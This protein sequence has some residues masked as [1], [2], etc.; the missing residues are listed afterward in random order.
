[1]SSRQVVKKIFANFENSNDGVIRQGITK[2]DHELL[3]PFVSLAEFS[4]SPPGGF[5]DHPHRGE[6]I[7]SFLLYTYT[8]PTLFYNG[9]LIHQDFN[10]NKGT[11]HEGDVLWTTAGR[12]IIHSE[13]PKEHTNIGLQL[14]VNL[15]SSDKMID[16]AN[17]EISSSEMPVAYEEGVEV[18]VI[19]GVSMGVQSPFYT[20]TPIMFL[21]II[22]QPRSQTHQTIPET[23]TAFAYVLDG[24]EGVFGSSDS[25]A[26]Q[27]H[28]LVVFGTGDEVSVWNTSNYRPLRFLLIAGE[29]IGESVVQHG[30]F[31]MNTQAEIDRTIWDYR[32]GQNGFEM[33]N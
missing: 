7:F 3:D 16:P 29:P 8:K 4:V 23:W 24:N 31:V 12:G 15:P 26:V 33:A 20:R 22:L 18:K 19:A 30:P 5:R 27:A 10:G 9:G 25:Y 1:M 2:S 32:N 6:V 21:D 13:M 17:V 28:T 11:V 14:W